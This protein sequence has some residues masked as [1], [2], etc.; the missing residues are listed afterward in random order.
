METLDPYLCGVA[1]KRALQKLSECLGD[2]QSK[3]ED[4]P[5]KEI[6]NLLQLMCS[7]VGCS[8]LCH[9]CVCI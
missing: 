1:V 9:V 6:L 5:M 4:L 8:I 2:E 7:K 3:Q